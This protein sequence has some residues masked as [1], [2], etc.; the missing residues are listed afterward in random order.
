MDAVGWDLELENDEADNV[1]GAPLG[2]TTCV[3]EV[4]ASARSRVGYLIL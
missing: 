1:G 2:G 3:R 4:S